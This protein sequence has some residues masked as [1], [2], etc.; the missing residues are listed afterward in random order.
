MSTITQI[1]LPD[2]QIIYARVSGQVP[3]AGGDDTAHDVGF[4]DKI[5]VLAREQL[6]KLAEG[7]VSNMLEAVRQ[8]DADEVSIDFGVEFTA[9]TGRVIGVLAEVGGNASVV[10][11]LTWRDQ[12]HPAGVTAPGVVSPTTQT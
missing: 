7:V 9:K 2:G 4:G 10:V 3:S 6:T 12:Q 5:P 11:H 1:Q 8:Y